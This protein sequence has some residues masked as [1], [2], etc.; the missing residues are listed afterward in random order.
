MLPQLAPL[1][2][3]APR[4]TPDRG[5][6]CRAAVDAAAGPGPRGRL[7]C[8][9]LVLEGRAGPAPTPTPAPDPPPSGPPALVA[10][11]GQQLV[12]GLREVVGQERVQNGVHA[13]EKE[14]E[15]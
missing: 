12:E 7:Q 8:R 10:A 1:P 6:L 15:F 4:A 14:K 2:P 9:Q 5:A 3:P 11:P 13:T